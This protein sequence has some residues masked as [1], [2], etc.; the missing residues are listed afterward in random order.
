[1]RTRHGNGVT[2][3]TLTGHRVVHLGVVNSTDIRRNRL[4]AKRLLLLSV[5]EEVERGVEMIGLVP[6][7][8]VVVGEESEVLFDVEW[9]GK[10]VLGGGNRI[11]VGNVLGHVGPVPAVV[12]RHECPGRRRC[13]GESP[14]GIETTFVVFCGGYGDVWYCCV[15]MS[16]GL[17]PTMRES[18]ISKQMRPP[19]W[20]P[21]RWGHQGRGEQ[22][23][24]VDGAVQSLE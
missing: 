11:Q 8:E 14:D 1:M 7:D 4:L 19:V 24:L 10:Q 12:A 3:E 20:H 13:S 21:V 18:E 23:A 16:N 22:R 6:V 15:K 2:G 9:L 5:V 17:F